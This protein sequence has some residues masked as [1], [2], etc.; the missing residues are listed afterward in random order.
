ML[1]RKSVLTNLTLNHGIDVCEEKVYT[2]YTSVKYC[3]IF[4]S[5]VLLRAKFIYVYVYRPT[6]LLKKGKNKD[7]TVAQLLIEGKKG[8][9][10][11]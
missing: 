4:K 11:R 2:S 10:N 1:Q 6:L 9:F 7:V 3:K 8:A 5:Y